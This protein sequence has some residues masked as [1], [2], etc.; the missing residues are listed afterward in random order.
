[1]RYCPL[2]FAASLA[3]VLTVGVPAVGR[4]QDAAPTTKSSTAS[5]DDPF[6]WLEEVQGEKALAWVEARNAASRAEL[7]KHEEFAVIEADTLALLDADDRIVFGSQ[8]GAWIYNFW[9][10]A[11]NPRGLYRRTSVAK[12]LDHKSEWDVVFDLDALAKEEGRAWVWKG[13][14]LRRPEVEGGQY[15]RGLMRLSVGG[16]DAVVVREFDIPTRAFVK[17]GFEL[18]EAKGS[19][20][21]ID[22]DAVF[23]KTDFGAGSLTD[24]G[25]PRIVKRWRRGTPLAAAETIFEGKQE[26]VSAGARRAH[27]GDVHLDW[28]T[29]GTSFYTTERYLLEDDAL[30]RLDLPTSARIHTYF[31]GLLFI[32]LKQDFDV[33]DAHFVRGSV[34]TI[35][36]TDLKAG[37]RTFTAFFV[38]TETTALQSI[39]RTKSHLLVSVLDNVRDRL[40]RYAHEGDAWKRDEIIF[41]GHGRIRAANVDA[42]RDTFFVSHSSFLQPTTLYHFT[43]KL[44][45][46]IVQQAPKRFDA[47]PY[48]SRQ[49]FATSK[50]GTRVPYFIV[51]RKDIERDGVNKTLLYAYGGF[52]ISMRPRYLGA[53]G[54]NWLDRG[55]VYV[56]ANI[57]GGGEF[58]PRWHDAALREKRH[59]AF[60]DFEAVAEALIAKKI[61]SP[62]YL[63]IKGGSNGGLLM[64][65]AVTRRPALYGA[66]VCQVPLLDMRRYSKL[67]AGASWIA[68]YGN[69]DVPEDWEFIKTYSPYHHVAADAKYPRVLFTTSTKDDRVHPGH[70]RKMVA[71]ML[72]FGHP[73]L[74]YENTEGGHAGA[75]NS[76]QRAYVDALVYTYLL[77]ELGTAQ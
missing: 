53:L 45:R 4:A 75:A 30:I 43:E 65:A 5:A 1:M 27:Y 28:V 46:R 71:R 12:Y 9:R 15:E 29:H 64:G 49:M 24:S 2:F 16:S 63:G 47:T 40:F 7:T 35:P 66:V 8:R 52:R 74:Y 36:L 44:E 77:S 19:L 60:E 59:K 56:L 13:M 67:L 76:A 54:K 57:R 48:E 10:D 20:G 11:A 55:G 17:G 72:A 58:G 51:T 3:T 31:D 69:P 26:S 25:Y 42:D 37:K 14:S 6:L 32:E 62:S 23:V 21:W 34:V 41:A 22:A 50:D 61:T 18:P 39:Q 68:E 70:A 33:G 73:V 38:P